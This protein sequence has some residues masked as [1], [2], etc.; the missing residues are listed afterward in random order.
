M[1]AVKIC[2]WHVEKSN[3]I[4]WRIPFTTQRIAPAWYQLQIRNGYLR[5]AQLAELPRSE[6]DP[7]LFSHSAYVKF[8]C[9]KSAVFHTLQQKLTIFES[10]REGGNEEKIR[11]CREWISLH[12]LSSSSFSLHF[13]SIFSFSLH[14]LASR[15]QESWKLRNPVLSGGSR[16]VLKCPIDQWLTSSHSEVTSI[17]S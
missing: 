16:V 17:K 8:F 9:D 6:F 7:E 5:P 15:M 3:Q 12:F 14:F 4:Y 2:T 1:Q 10:E 13:L 11:K